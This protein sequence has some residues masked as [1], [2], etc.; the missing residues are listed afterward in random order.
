M[1]INFQIYLHLFLSLPTDT[2]YSNF[3]VIF[4]CN[5]Y[6]G[7]ANGQSLWILGR[8]RFLEPQFM[9]KAMYAVNYNQ[10]SKFMLKHVDQNCADNPYPY[11]DPQAQSNFGNGR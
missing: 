2:D 5:N 6:Y 9:E 10:L 11:S 7:I 1:L 4:A 8:R 3:A